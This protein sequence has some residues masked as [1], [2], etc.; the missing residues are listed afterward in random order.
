MN[1]RGACLVLV[2]V[3]G[4]KGVAGVQP[5]PDF[6]GTWTLVEFRYGEKVMPTDNPMVSGAVLN[7]GQ[8][9]TITQAAESLAL[10]RT[11]TPKDPRPRDEAVF[12]DGRPMMNQRTARWEAAI[13]RLSQRLGG[14]VVTQTLAIEQGKLVFE[15]TVAETKVAP[16]TL[17]YERV[18]DRH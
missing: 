18:T 5:K 2:L 15:T 6:S 16:Y 3:L 10:S 14:L 7:C 17:T 13:L 12:L 9:C 8:R 1:L 4:V 11:P